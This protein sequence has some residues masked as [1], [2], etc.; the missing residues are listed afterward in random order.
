MTPSYL[1]NI[2]FTMPFANTHTGSPSPSLI[3]IGV[4]PAQMLPHFRNLPCPG[5]WVSHSSREESC[6]DR[7]SFPPPCLGSCLWPTVRVP[8]SAHDIGCTLILVTLCTPCIQ[9]AYRIHQIMM[10]SV[11]I[12]L[13]NVAFE[14]PNALY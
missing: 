1:C 9:T 4:F 13:V 6:G 5:A 14:F 3:P 7:F 12:Q 8:N 2:V 11:S 10:T